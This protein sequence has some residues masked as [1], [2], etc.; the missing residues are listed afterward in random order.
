MG[1][2]EHGLGSGL[3]CRNHVLYIG[4]SPCIVVTAVVEGVI[5]VVEVVT[6]QV[7]RSLSWRCT[8]RPMH[9][10]GDVME[11]DNDD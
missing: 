9:K 8:Q 5:S 2:W 4:L 1:A 3:Q 10:Q 6:W 11:I 7:N